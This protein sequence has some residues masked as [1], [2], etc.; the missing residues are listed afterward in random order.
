[1]NR[2]NILHCILIVNCILIIL[3]MFRVFSEYSFLSLYQNTDQIQLE[4]KKGSDSVLF[5]DELMEIATDINSDIMIERK[6]QFGEIDFYRT[7]ARDSF[8][9]TLISYDWNENY[10][11]SSSPEKN[12]KKLHGFFTDIPVNIKPIHMALNETDLS[13]VTVLVSCE[14]SDMFLEYCIEKNILCTK[15]NVASVQDYFSEWIGVLL[16]FLFFLFISVVFYAFSCRRDTIV[17]KSMGYS[18]L[19]ICTAQLKSS[20][21]VFLLILCSVL[22]LSTTVFSFIFGFVSSAM[23]NSLIAISFVGLLVFLIIC[24][25]AAFV[26]IG[27]NSKISD[28]KGKS[29][30]KDFL[31]ITDIFMVVILLFLLNTV[32]GI[33]IPGAVSDYN[34]VKEI[35][36]Q[37]EDYFTFNVDSLER[38]DSN[39][40]KYA[41]CLIN[42]Y[43]KLHENGLI[44]VEE[45]YESISGDTLIRVNDNYINFCDNLKTPDGKII[46]SEMLLPD[47]HNYLV[48]ENLETVYFENMR[49][50]SKGKIDNTNIIYYSP[51]SDFYLLSNALDGKRI[52]NA[53]IDVWDL[54]YSISTESEHTIY[55]YLTSFFTHAFFMKYD[56][57][58]ST[59]YEQI[60]SLFSE[61]D[62]GAFIST[63]PFVNE[64][65]AEYFNDVKTEMLKSFYKALIFLFAFFT[66]TVFSAELYCS[67]YLHEIAVKITSGYSVTEIIHFRLI[68]MLSLIPAE[69]IINRSGILSGIIDINDIV[70]IIGVLLEV[71]IYAMIVKNK[72]LNKT[73]SVLKGA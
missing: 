64:L 68:L 40:E 70:M 38:Y 27:I 50:K 48:P 67:C 25:L 71:I 54:E 56:E 58:F 30:Q 31:F 66:V 53:I 60:F 47:K 24:Y 18:T 34:R 57:A 16:A 65:Y 52:K 2:K 46:T 59:P 10:I 3:C 69:L 41:D 19:Q 22:I 6:N 8:Q 36:S 23:F 12:E 49:N 32:S 42:I 17:K 1:M 43:R 35:R 45:A 14:A 28:I 15:E 20:V 73:Y 26:Y 9:N 11:Y 4:G 13:S 37:Y 39:T 63:T 29:N 61:N 44:M 7:T 51:E 33:N 5:I 21:K 72:S 55:M 62:M